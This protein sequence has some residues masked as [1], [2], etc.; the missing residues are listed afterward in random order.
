MVFLLLKHGNKKFLFTGDA[1]EEAE[2][3]ML[4]K[5]LVPKVDVLKVGA[6][7]GKRSDN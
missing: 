7:W 5:G 4:A 6:S 3:D 2:S 1:E